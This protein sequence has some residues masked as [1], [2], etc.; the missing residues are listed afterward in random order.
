MLG[1]K[2]AA[3]GGD[4]EAVLV[5]PLQVVH[6]VPELVDVAI[7][8]L[9][10]LLQGADVGLEVGGLQLRGELLLGGGH[11]LLGH[12]G[13]TRLKLGFFLRNLEKK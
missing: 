7:E 13:Q 8:R 1:A 2:L 5:L 11:Q 3:T 4:G 6:L 10:L 9:V 12:P